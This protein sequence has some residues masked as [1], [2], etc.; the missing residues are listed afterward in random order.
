MKNNTTC[1]N[2]GL[3]VVDIQGSLARMVFESERRIANMSKLIKGC[4]ILEMPIVWLEQ[5]PKG[6]GKTIPEIAIL[7]EDLKP[8]EKNCFN[9]LSNETIKKAIA[10]HRKNNWLVCGIES[11]ICVYQTAQ[12]LLENNYTAEVVIDCISS[13]KQQS[14]DVAIKKLQ[15]LGVGITDLE[16]CLYELVGTSQNEAFKKIL[17][18]IKS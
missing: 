12:G 7:F 11:H 13:R 16:M 18:L 15:Q 6:L 2:S 17:P 9:A 14:I 4:Q 3:V 5:Y 1:L 10:N 8:M